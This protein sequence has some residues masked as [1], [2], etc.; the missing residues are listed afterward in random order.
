MSARSIKQLYTNWMANAFYN[1][2]RSSTSHHP[3]IFSPQHLFENG[4]VENIFMDRF[5]IKFSNEFTTMLKRFEPSIAVGGESV[6]KCYSLSISGH[7][8]VNLCLMQTR[9]HLFFF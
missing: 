8:A 7:H 4:R 1:F 3:N 2:S 9:P 5:Y 6:S